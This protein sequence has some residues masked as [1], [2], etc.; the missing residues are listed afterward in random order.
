MDRFERSVE[1]R[2]DRRV[3]S[4]S[5]LNNDY[6]S[7][8]RLGSPMLMS[9]LSARKTNSLDTRARRN[10]RAKPASSARD[11]SV[12]FTGDTWQLRRGTLNYGR[13]IIG[14]ITWR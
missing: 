3:P 13:V 9:D 6:L 14:T 2:P 4:L 8:T 10:P 12:T 7:A 1:S 5:R 11:R